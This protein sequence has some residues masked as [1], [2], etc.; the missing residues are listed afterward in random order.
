[1]NTKELIDRQGLNEIATIFSTAEKTELLLNK[2]DFPNDRIPKFQNAAD[3]WQRICNELDHGIINGGCMRLLEAAAG[4]YS[5]NPLFSKLIKKSDPALEPRTQAVIVE[6]KEIVKPKK[7][8]ES[9]KVTT[10]KKMGDGYSRLLNGTWVGSI[11]TH[12]QRLVAVIEQYHM[13][14]DCYVRGE[15]YNLSNGAVELESEWNSKCLSVDDQGFIYAI[16]HT[17]ICGSSSIIQHRNGFGT[18]KL[19][20]KY[21]TGRAYDEP[22]IEND[23]QVIKAYKYNLEKISDSILPFKKVSKSK[24]WDNVRAMIG[25]KSH[26]YPG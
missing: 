12:E 6:S 18:L 2:I 20:G 11:E 3:F 9:Q 4:L 13:L 10:P 23:T 24:K 21:I 5:A 14:S 25:L 17:T 26:R 16:Y 8:T 19:D 22:K 1:M 15:S 7:V